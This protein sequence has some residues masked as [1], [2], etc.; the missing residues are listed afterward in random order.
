MAETHVKYNLVD[1][2]EDDAVLNDRDKET[3]AFMYRVEVDDLKLKLN[4]RTQMVVERQTARLPR[5]VNCRVLSFVDI[6]DY[7]MSTILKLNL[8]FVLYNA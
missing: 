4:K 6:E 1:T 8:F 3:I 2:E 7:S 5:T